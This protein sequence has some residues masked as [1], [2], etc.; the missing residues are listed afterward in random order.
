LRRLHRRLPRG[1]APPGPAREHP[2]PRPARRPRARPGARD[3]PRPR[4]AR[5]SRRRRVRAREPGAL[6]V[7]M[8]ALGEARRR[9]V[10]SW[11]VDHLPAIGVFVVF[12]A[13][14]QLAVSLLG[15]RE[16][17]LPSPGAV[18]RAM[19]SDEVP[20]ARHTWV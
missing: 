6:A 15:I 19:L 20:W 18:V 2:L 14:W 9:R 8:S 7:G 3:R 4:R 1:A 13:V 12:V 16:Y 17:L 11:A 10:P 5:R